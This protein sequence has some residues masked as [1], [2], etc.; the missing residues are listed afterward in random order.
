LNPL[1]EVALIRRQDAARYLATT[2]R[3]LDRWIADGAGPPFHRIRGRKYFT[4]SDLDAWIAS[5]KV[6]QTE[7]MR[8]HARHGERAA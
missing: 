7:T 2:T 6:R 1:A 4:M 8:D 5:T 3:T